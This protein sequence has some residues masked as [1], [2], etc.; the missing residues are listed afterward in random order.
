MRV[1]FYLHGEFLIKSLPRRGLE[2]PHLLVPIPLSFH[3]CYYIFLPASSLLVLTM[4]EDMLS[5]LRKA[6]LVRNLPHQRQ[7]SSEM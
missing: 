2:P 3:P 4:S 1:S 7:K 5:H 6:I